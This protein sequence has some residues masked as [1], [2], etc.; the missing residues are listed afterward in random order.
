MP[1]PCKDPPLA[2]PDEGP[3]IIVSAEK[4][5]QRGIGARLDLV[6]SGTNMPTSKLNAPS[7]LL[8]PAQYI[9]TFV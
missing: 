1:A 2:S 4:H 9:S 8:L 5:C 6:R 7:Y 3:V